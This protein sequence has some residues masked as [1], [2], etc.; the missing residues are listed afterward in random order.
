[1]TSTAAG[2]PG[3]TAVGGPPTWQGPEL[4]RAGEISDVQDNRLRLLQRPGGDGT[5][6]TRYAAGRSG[7]FSARRRLDDM[8]RFCLPLPPLRADRRRRRRGSASAASALRFA[9]CVVI[10]RGHV[11][12]DPQ[13]VASCTTTA[14][15]PWTSTLT[16]CSR[17]PWCSPS[18]RRPICASPPR[19]RPHVPGDVQGRILE[20]VVSAS[21]H[22]PAVRRRMASAAS[23]GSATAPP[24]SFVMACSGLIERVLT[25]GPWKAAGRGARLIA[26]AGTMRMRT[27]ARAAADRNRPRTA[28]LAASEPALAES[29]TQ[30]TTAEGAAERRQVLMS[31][32]AAAALA[33]TPSSASRGRGAGEGVLADS[34]QHQRHRPR[35]EVRG[36]GGDPAQ[37]EAAEGYGQPAASRIALPNRWVRPARRKQV[38]D[39]HGER[40]AAWAGCSRARRR[41]VAKKKKPIIGAAKRGALRRPRS[42]LAKRCSAS[43]A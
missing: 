12:R 25:R 15:S 16:D 36:R 4:L 27:A 31:P 14:V 21:L 13:I 5:V 43:A 38:H 2:Q 29:A 7:A 39:R 11:A 9:R 24:V 17:M 37:P 33:V 35:G 30:D 10:S 22:H 42:R 41:W 18:R 34:D 1:M 23:E 26:S 8:A 20:L 19:P 6:P 3:R 32:E 28:A 40:D